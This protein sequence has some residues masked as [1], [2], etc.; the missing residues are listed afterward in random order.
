MSLPCTFRYVWL[1]IFNYFSRFLLAAGSC[2]EDDEPA[3]AEA[4]EIAEAEAEADEGADIDAE[5]EADEGADIDA[6]AEADEGAEADAEV[7]EVADADLFLSPHRHRSTPPEQISKEAETSCRCVN[8]QQTRQ[9]HDHWHT[10]CHG[11][12][13]S[14]QCPMCMGD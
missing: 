9:P 6:D 7:D 2:A 10:E 13:L 4:D 3:D 14:V 12:H 5:A 8:L 11:L 1:L